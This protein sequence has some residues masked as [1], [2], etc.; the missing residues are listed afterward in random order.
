MFNFAAINRTTIAR[1][2][3]G[4]SLDIKLDPVGIACDL[5]ICV[6]IV[7]VPSVFHLVGTHTNRCRFLTQLLDVELPQSSLNASHCTTT[8]PRI[9]QCIKG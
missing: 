5:T 4:K 6:R 3:S 1:I 2:L 8:R 9:C 7:A